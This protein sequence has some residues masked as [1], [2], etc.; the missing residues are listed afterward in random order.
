[1]VRGLAA[2]RL[3]YAI[4]LQDPYG[5]VHDNGRKVPERRILRR[6]TAQPKLVSLL[7]NWYSGATLLTIFL[8]AH[9][10]IVS[11]GE[12]MF[13]DDD[14]SR[15]YVCSCGKYIDECE[16]YE[17]TTASMRLPNGGGWDKRL[18]VQVPRFSRRP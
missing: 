10:K 9:S 11:N 3:S 12:S 6:M 5:R 2:V 1:M 18:F 4:L 13:F 7:A 17:S 14:D 16:F 15:R 8:N